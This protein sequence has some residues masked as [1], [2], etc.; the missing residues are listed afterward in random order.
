[1]FEKNATKKADYVYFL[2]HKLDI[3]LGITTMSC[4]HYYLTIIIISLNFI[5]VNKKERPRIK[6]P[7]LKN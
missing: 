2:T 5:F 3:R 1:M 7:Y 4:E 6:T